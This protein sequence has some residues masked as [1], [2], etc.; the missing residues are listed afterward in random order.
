MYLSRNGGPWEHYY[1]TDVFTIYGDSPDDDFEVLTTLARGYKTDYYDVLIDLYEY[2]Y[3]DVVAT[4]SGDDSDGLYALPL[5][6]SDRD[7]GYEVIHAGA[8]GGLSLSLLGL[9]AFI[10]RSYLAK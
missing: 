2:G 6:S 1:T 8:F 5:E 4:I 9:V 3:N 7:E 10:R